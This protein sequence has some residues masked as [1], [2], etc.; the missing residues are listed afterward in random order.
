MNDVGGE[1]VE[2]QE[3]LLFAAPV[4]IFYGGTRYYGEWFRYDCA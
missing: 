3:P 4:A 1:D 2:S